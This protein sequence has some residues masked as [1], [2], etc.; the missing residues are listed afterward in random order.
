MPAVPRVRDTLSVSPVADAPGQHA[1]CTREGAELFRLSPEGVFLLAQLD[2]L[3]TADEVLLAYE[4]RFDQEMSK[5]ELAGFL[6]GL[7]DAGVFHDDPV[8]VSALR[9]VRAQGLAWR[10]AVVDRRS[11]VD[12]R[13][14]RREG[15]RREVESVVTQWWDHAVFHLNTGHIDH[16]IDI[17][18]RMSEAA[19]GDLRLR[20]IAAHLRFLNLQGAQREDRRDVGWE[21]FD[22]ALEDM[23]RGGNC[24]RCRQRLHV[25]AGRQNR[26]SGCGGSFSAFVLERVAGSRREDDGGS[27]P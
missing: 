17:L 8:V 22:A 3:T 26:C 11:R 16:A 14:E 21:V 4:E 24:P 7:A 6:D 9:Y 18:D 20:E 19:P 27:A 5:E 10:G 23:L 25:E 1:V 12:E 15:G 13:Q 2:G